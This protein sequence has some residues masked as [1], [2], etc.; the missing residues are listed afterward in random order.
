MCSARPLPCRLLRP[1]LAHCCL[2]HHARPQPRLPPLTWPW[3]CPMSPRH[4]PRHARP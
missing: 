4:L 3:S 2:R 1:G